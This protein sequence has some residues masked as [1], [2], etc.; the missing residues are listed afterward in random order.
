MIQSPPKSKYD[1]KNLINLVTQQYLKNRG[2]DLSHLD[3]L[4]IDEIFK[5]DIFLFGISEW[6]KFFCIHYLGKSND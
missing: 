6:N 2:Y 3:A 5:S 4:G 1:S